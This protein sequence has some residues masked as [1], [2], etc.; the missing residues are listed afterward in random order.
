MG[1]LFTSNTGVQDLLDQRNKRS[2]DLQQQLMQQASQGARDPAKAQAISMVGSLFG[3]ALAGKVEGTDE[4]MEKL[5][6]AEDEQV[7]MQKQYGS[8]SSGTAAQQ[9]ELAINLNAAGYF[10]KAAEVKKS[11]IALEA[12]EKLERE[13]ALQASLDTEANL[14]L[15]DGIREKNAVLA[16]QV[17]RGNPDAI[18]LALKIASPENADKIVKQGTYR[19]ADNKLVAGYVQGSARFVYGPDGKPLPMPNDAIYIGEDSGATVSQK[20][21]ATFTERNQKI[22]ALMAL[23]PE[24]GG[25]TAEEGAKR[26]NNLKSALSMEMDPNITKTAAQDALNISNYLTTANDATDK[27]GK[28]IASYQQSL[29][30]LDAGMY[31]GVGAGTF[32]AVRKLAI[33]SGLAGKDLVIDAGNVEQFRANIM[34]SV[35]DRVAETKGAI[36]QQEMVAF[37]KASIGLDKT[38][39]GNRLLLE[40][41]V[42]A[43]RWEQARSDFINTKYAAA[44]KDNKLLKRYE[45]KEYV[46]EWEENNLLVL[47]T[48]AEMEEAKSEGNKVVGSDQV[49]TGKETATELYNMVNALED[50]N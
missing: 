13:T 45:M 25:I 4:R 21:L 42:K 1:G 41:A 2:S 33:A 39:A 19:L 7:A 38:V 46:K 32:Q 16:E 29:A 44:R 14:E 3:R 24:S 23:P 6:A 20:K 36:S 12:K 17:E 5:Q 28:I 37:A 48:A 22:T 9:N 50:I 31:T 8:M 35:L 15:A 40:T 18:K 26:I 43:E 11:A 10:Q 34:D 47:P 30:M 49:L 27:S